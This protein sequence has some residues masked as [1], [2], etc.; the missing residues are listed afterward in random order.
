MPEPIS[1]LR[2]VVADD[3]VV[4]RQGVVRILGD[5]GMTVVARLGR[6]MSCWR[7]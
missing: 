6:P 3:S 1:D 4:I 2:V 7:W 5:A